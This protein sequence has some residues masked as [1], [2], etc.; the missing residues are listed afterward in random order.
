MLI[1]EVD[2]DNVKPSRLRQQLFFEF[3]T[4]ICSPSHLILNYHCKDLTYL[5]KIIDIVIDLFLFKSYQNKT[6]LCYFLKVKMSI[7]SFFIN[8]ILLPF[9]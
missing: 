6:Q 4:N 1:I 3:P 2:N 9:R 5:E 8:V 7:E